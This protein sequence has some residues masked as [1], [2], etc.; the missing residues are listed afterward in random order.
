M[1][2]GAG[3]DVFRD[4]FFLV[5]INFSRE[6]SEVGVS[7]R[8]DAREGGGVAAEGAGFYG[9][10]VG[11]DGD[12]EAVDLENEFGDAVFVRDFVAGEDGADAEDGGESEEGADDDPEEFRGE[13]TREAL[14]CRR[15]GGGDLVQV[16]LFIH[17][18][19][20]ISY[21]GREGGDKVETGG[22]GC[23]WAIC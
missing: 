22:R 4:V 2:G 7:A 15:G 16:F 23:G 10:L 17:A 9:R 21:A 8:E 11:V 19:I 6:G 12:V 18:I 3:L 20:I 5:I 14:F 1:F 13:E